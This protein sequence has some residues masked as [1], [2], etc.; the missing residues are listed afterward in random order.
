M[1]KKVLERGYQHR[2]LSLEKALSGKGG[3][4]GIPYRIGSERGV[5][6]ASRIGVDRPVRGQND[7][8]SRGDGAEDVKG[9]SFFPAE[10]S[11]LS[12]IHDFTVLSGAASSPHQEETHIL[13]AW[14][15]NQEEGGSRALAD[16]KLLP[17][18]SGQRA[19][20]DTQGLKS[21]AGDRPQ[22]ARKEEPGVAL[23][24]RPPPHHAK[25]G[26]EG[27]RERGAGAKPKAGEG[28]TDR[29]RESEMAARDRGPRTHR[30]HPISLVGRD[31][32]G[33]GG[34]GVRVSVTAAPSAAGDDRG[35]AADGI[36]QM[37]N[38]DVEYLQRLVRGSSGV[39]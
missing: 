32:M 24:P 6:G 19:R 12:S 10:S 38:E 36:T 26:L 9:D 28:Q 27:A 17:G 18:F 31:I 5:A 25:M 15:R 11:V 14:S 34:A 13:G 22:E 7:D 29:H 33:T 37:L 4:G 35:G 8:S 20:G 3:G 23:V 21:A 39:L 1:A 2:A 30:L 16:G